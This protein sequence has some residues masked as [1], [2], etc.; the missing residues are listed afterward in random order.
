MIWIC[1]GGNAGEAGTSIAW[2]T[3]VP[4]EKIAVTAA[5]TLVT[6]AQVSGLLPD[7]DVTTC[8]WTARSPTVSATAFWNMAVPH[9]GRLSMA[10][11][12]SRRWEL[13]RLLSSSS[14]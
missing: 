9:V 13:R 7:F 3:A 5:R 6:L 4:N 14:K 1:V 10:A 8:Q 2:K 12:I 11:I